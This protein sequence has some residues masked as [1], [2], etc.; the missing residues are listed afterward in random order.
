MW[1]SA[2]NPLEEKVQVL[3][4]KDEIE[5]IYLEKLSHLLNFTPDIVI[6]LFIDFVVFQEGVDIDLLGTDGCFLAQG[7]QTAKKMALI[8]THFG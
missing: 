7:I 5:R 2:D 6:G 8:F 4:L 3:L 1:Q